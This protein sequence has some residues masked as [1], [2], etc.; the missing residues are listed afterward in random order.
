MQN[1]SNLGLL[2]EEFSNFGLNEGVGKMCASSA[3]FVYNIL[4]LLTYQTPF[5]VTIAELST[6]KQVRFFFGPPCI[7]H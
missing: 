4:K 3:L 7:Y 1:F 2:Q 5:W 6:L